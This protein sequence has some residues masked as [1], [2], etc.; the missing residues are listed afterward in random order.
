MLRAAECG[1]PTIL[2]RYRPTTGYG[3]R[4]PL[5]SAPRNRKDEPHDFAP[6]ETWGEWPHCGDER[7]RSELAKTP[8]DLEV[9]E[10]FH[11]EAT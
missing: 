2:R 7:H 4:R 10:A 9:V 5:L 11:G 6:L 3:G 8:T 1:T